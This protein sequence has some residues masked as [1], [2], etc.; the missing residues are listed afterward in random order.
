MHQIVDIV[1]KKP[2]AAEAKLDEVAVAKAATLAAAAPAGQV[3]SA[4]Q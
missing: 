2:K 1:T 3:I 4:E